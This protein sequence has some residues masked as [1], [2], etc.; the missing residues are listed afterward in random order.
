MGVCLRREVLFIAAT[1]LWR[2][3]IYCHQACCLLPAPTFGLFSAQKRVVYSAPCFW[4]RP[5]TCSMG[6]WSRAVAQFSIDGCSAG[7]NY[8]RLVR[9]LTATRD[10]KLRTMRFR[11]CRCRRRAFLRSD[12]RGQSV[13]LCRDRLSRLPGCSIFFRPAGDGV[14]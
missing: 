12:L 9:T 4:R 7:R 14:R 3:G 5:G 11:T 6:A 10:R 8:I 1:W 2:P 13:K